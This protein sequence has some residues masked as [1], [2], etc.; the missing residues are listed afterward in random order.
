MATRVDD[1]VGIW[2]A[3]YQ[4]KPAYMQYNADGTYT[5][6]ESV[7]NLSSKPFVSGKF[8]FEGST[9][10]VRDDGCEVEGTYQILLIK[11]NNAPTLKFQGVKDLCA[12][13]SKDL[14]YTM[15]KVQP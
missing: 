5:L 9:F 10:H 3:R 13:R 11:E 12:E 15:R 2:T 1:L 7:A 4:G 6:A 14:R 8:W